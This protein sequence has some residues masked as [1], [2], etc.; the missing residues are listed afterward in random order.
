MPPAPIVHSNF[1]CPKWPRRKSCQG[2][3][4]RR[5]F[6]GCRSCLLEDTCG[7]VR[8]TI[9]SIAPHDLARLSRFCGLTYI[10]SCRGASISASREG[11]SRRPAAAR[12]QAFLGLQ[13]G[14]P[15]IR[16]STSALAAEIPG[17]IGSDFAVSLLGY[18]EIDHIV[19]I[20]SDTEIGK[21]LGPVSAGPRTQ[22]R[23]RPLID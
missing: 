3:A 9:T 10:S 12:E 20:T 16:S 19:F 6:G 7:A 18:P 17:A 14:H 1:R 15:N 8:P 22:P 11:N 2:Y 13:S 21:R 4:N 5:S 23:D